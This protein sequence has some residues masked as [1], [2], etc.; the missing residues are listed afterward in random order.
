MHILRG[1]NRLGE[2]VFY[3][4]GA[5]DNWVSHNRCEAFAYMTLEG[6]TRKAKLFNGRHALTGVFFHVNRMEVTA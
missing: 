1:V 5:G 6:A 3:T 4:G 2:E